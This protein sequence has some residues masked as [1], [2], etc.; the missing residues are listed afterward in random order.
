MLIVG[1]G[2]SRKNIS[3][4]SILTCKIGCNA[5][6]RDYHVDHLIC[7]DRRMVEEAINSKTH[8]I[9]YTR[10]DWI[11]LYKEYKGIQ[12]VPELPYIG[13]QRW[14]EPFQWG[15]GPYAVL[16][17][18]SL[19]KKNK[20]DLI[21]FDLYSKQKTVNNIYKNTNGYDPSSKNAVDPS[22]WIYQIS[23][24]FEWFPKITFT[25]Y[26]ENLWQLPNTWKKDNVLLDKISNL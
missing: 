19:C 15:S 23:K 13:N 16:L 26:Q 21:G 1:N 22:Y 18:A 24:V 6:I 9:I 2:E 8:S 12:T 17:G 5:I 4:D 3:I 14:D 25:I 20:I 10:K 7:V 11:N